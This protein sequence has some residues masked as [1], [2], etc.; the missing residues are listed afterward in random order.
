LTSCDPCIKPA[1]ASGNSWRSLH[2]AGKIIN[3]YEHARHSAF[4]I[5]HAP[6]YGMRQK[7]QLIASFI[8]GFHHGISNKIMR[9]YRYAMMLNQDDWQ[10]VRRLSLLLALSEAADVTYEG[11]VE[12]FEVTNDEEGVVL[13]VRGGKGASHSAADFEMKTYAKQFKKE[14]GKP[15]II[16]WHKD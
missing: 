7:E 11:I 13:A 12:S 16:L 3:Y 1:N 5:A 2:D 4:I 8:A 10:L 6:I 9:S 15:L 14:Y